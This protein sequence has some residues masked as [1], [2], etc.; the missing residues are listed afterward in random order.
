MIVGAGVGSDVGNDVGA[1]GVFV[2]G[3]VVGFFVHVGARV[4]PY[5][6][7][8]GAAVGSYWARAAASSHKKCIFMAALFIVA[9]G[10][11]FLW[12]E[13]VRN[14]PTAGN[15]APAGS[16]AAMTESHLRIGWCRTP[17]KFGG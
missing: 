7:G 14:F 17:C 11:P 2:G 10:C 15:A 12:S 13:A 8:A 5:V 3:A 4:G 6:G 1:V 16:R 9:H